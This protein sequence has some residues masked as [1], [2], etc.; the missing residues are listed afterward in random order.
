MRYCSIFRSAS[1]TYCSIFR[2]ACMRYCSIFR[3]ACKILF[4]F[5]VS[6]YEILFHFQ[7]SLY[8]ILFHFQI[9]LYEILF[10]FQISLYEI[11]FHFQIS[12]YE[13][14]NF[15]DLEMFVKRHV[16]HVSKNCDT[17]YSPL[18]DTGK[19]KIRCT[20]KGTKV[21][22]YHIVGIS[23]LNSM[24]NVVSLVTCAESL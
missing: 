12:L 16:S 21:A 23:M 14:K 19:N 10:H 9:S 17:S 20:P 18:D 4:H 22:I 6:L 5:Q 2:S 15:K 3:S 7:I 13:F 24:H 11:L 1:M 8:D